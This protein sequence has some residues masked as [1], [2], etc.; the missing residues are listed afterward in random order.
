[1]RAGAEGASSI[2]GLTA[3]AFV[4]QITCSGWSRAGEFDVELADEVEVARG[5]G[6]EVLSLVG[7]VRLTSDARLELVLVGIALNVTTSP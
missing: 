2:G 6:G 3:G 1:M 4:G 7:R 5:L